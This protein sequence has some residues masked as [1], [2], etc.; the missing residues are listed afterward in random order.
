MPASKI[1][2]VDFYSSH[3]II[4]TRQDIS[5]LRKHIER[6]HSLYCHLGLPPG[7]FHNASVLEFGPGSGHNA[8]VT[9][10]LVPRRYLLVDGN[11]PSLAS[12]NRLLGRHCPKLKFELRQSSIASF[13]SDERFDIVLCEAVIPTQKNPPRFLKHVASFVRAEGILVFTCMDA[14]SL[15]PELLRRW[16]A[17][18]LVREIPAFDAQVARLVDFFG[19]DIAALPGM[20]RRPEDWVIDQI[21]HPWVGPLFSIPEAVSA[22]GNGATILGCSPRFLIDWRWYK[23]IVGRRCTDNSFAIDS[24]YE[25]GLNLLDYRVSLPPAKRNVVRRIESL[26][27]EICAGVFA[28]ENGEGEFSRRQLLAAMKLL[29]KILSEYSPETCRSAE[30]FIEYLRTNLKRERT[31]TDFRK[32]WGRGQQ[33]LSCIIR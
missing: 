2:F 6:R 19:P 11:P 3:G 25:L 28:R 26:S 14:I 32:W 27:Q 17:R 4:P 1:P 16:L 29:A 24:Y 23:S 12:T 31:L 9:G 18:D 20:S 30:S 10:L 7:V 33:Y 15:L 13:R 22:L 21:L 5:N 8:I